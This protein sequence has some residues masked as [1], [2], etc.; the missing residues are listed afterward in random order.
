MTRTSSENEMRFEAHGED[1][2]QLEMKYE[3]WKM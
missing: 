3:I 2:R 1:A